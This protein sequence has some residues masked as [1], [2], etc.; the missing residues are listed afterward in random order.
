MERNALVRV[1]TLFYGRYVSERVVQKVC[2]GEWRV[3]DEDGFDV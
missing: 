1:F 3:S 2:A